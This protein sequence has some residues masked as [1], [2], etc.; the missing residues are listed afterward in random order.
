MEVSNTFVVVMGVGTVF[1]GL[2][3]IVI[4]CKIIGLFCG[5]Y[6]KQKKEVKQQTVVNAPTQSAAG[7]PAVNKGELVAAISA[8]IAEELGTDVTGIRILSIKKM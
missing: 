2:L 5:A 1:L 4:L 8:A 7:Q 3:C 6:S